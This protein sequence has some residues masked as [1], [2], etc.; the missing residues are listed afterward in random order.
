MT[1]NAGGNVESA[2]AEVVVGN[3]LVRFYSDPIRGSNAATR[4]PLLLLYFLNCI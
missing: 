3:V 1:R 2:T 4:E